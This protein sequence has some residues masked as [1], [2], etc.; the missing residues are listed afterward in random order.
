[1]LY[2]RVCYVWHVILVL[3]HESVHGKPYGGPDNFSGQLFAVRLEAVQ[4]GALSGVVQ[5][6]EQ[7]P[8]LAPTWAPSK[9]TQ[10]PRQFTPNV[11]RFQP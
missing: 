6:D 2:N 3:T 5:A 1:M 10:Y 9:D 4:Q 7:H 8:G 11:H